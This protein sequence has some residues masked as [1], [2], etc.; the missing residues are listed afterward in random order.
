MKV[1]KAMKK[2]PGEMYFMHSVALLLA[3]GGAAVAIRG[4]PI[5]ESMIWV[6]WLPLVSTVIV[7]LLMLWESRQQRKRY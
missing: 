5:M 1:M 6:L 2:I 7:D 3:G 4:V